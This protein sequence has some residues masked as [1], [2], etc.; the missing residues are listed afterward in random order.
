MKFQVHVT[1]ILM[2]CLV[3]ACIINASPS[4]YL[5]LSLDYVILFLPDST[6]Q[7]FMYLF[8]KQVL[9]V[10]YELGT[11]LGLKMPLR[12]LQLKKDVM[13]GVLESY[14]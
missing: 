14:K 8:N 12:T 1:G 5:N 4:L 9:R 10:L 2:M 13:E 11:V 3:H 6:E 7:L